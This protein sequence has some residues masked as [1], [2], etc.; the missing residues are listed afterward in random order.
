MKV[1]P[2]LQVVTDLHNQRNSLYSAAK[3]AGIKVSTL[4]RG[5]DVWVL[6]HEEKNGNGA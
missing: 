1:P 2:G 3:T 6:R 5:G 4:V